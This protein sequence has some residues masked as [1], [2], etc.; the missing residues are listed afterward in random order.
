[1]ASCRNAMLF[2]SLTCFSP[3]PSSGTVQVLL[4]FRY[5]PRCRK[6]F[7][8]LW[9]SGVNDKIYIQNSY[10]IR[11]KSQNEPLRQL[12][13]VHGKTLSN[14]FSI[15]FTHSV[16][17]DYGWYLVLR[18]VNLNFLHLS[19]H[20]VTLWHDIRYDQYVSDMNVKHNKTIWWNFPN[21]SWL[22]LTYVW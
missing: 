10:K 18:L 3:R 22:F 5:C 14:I 6:R 16:T 2:G 21:S 17:W 4:G 15:P 8:V 13:N 11:R 19:E 1:M 12:V 9:W 20:N 7:C